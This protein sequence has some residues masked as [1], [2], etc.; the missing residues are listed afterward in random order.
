MANFEYASKLSYRE[1]LG[2]LQVTLL[3]ILAQV[4]YLSENSRYDG[5]GSIIVV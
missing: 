2:R 3:N 1:N 4:L 5:L